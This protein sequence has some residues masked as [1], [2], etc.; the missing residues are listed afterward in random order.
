MTEM[1]R[2]HEWRAGWRSN[3][4]STLWGKWVLKQQSPTGVW[5]K[6]WFFFLKKEKRWRQEGRVRKRC[7]H[8]EEQK[9]VSYRQ[10]ERHRDGSDAWVCGTISSKTLKLVESSPTEAADVVQGGR[11]KSPPGQSRLVSVH[12]CGFKALSD[13]LEC[14]SSAWQNAAAVPGL[15]ELSARVWGVW[16]SWGVTMSACFAIRLWNWLL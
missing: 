3:E 11:K 4:W 15:D 7:T 5:E 14:D 13:E 10:G 6:A 2:V 12:F 1:S 16:C 8:P 9:W